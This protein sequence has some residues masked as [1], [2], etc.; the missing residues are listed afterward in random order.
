[1]KNYLAEAMHAIGDIPAG[2]PDE[3]RRYAMQLRSR[4]Y[5]YHHVAQ[6]IHNAIADGGLIDGGL[7]N[8]LK[9]EAQSLTADIDGRLANEVNALADYL[10][11]EA[12]NLAHS[13]EDKKRSLKRLADQLLHRDQQEE[14]QRKQAGRGGGGSW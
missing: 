2:N 12:T 4:A 10:D 3:M 14:A 9:S 11:R 7:A 13:Q 8:R 5:A 6:E 1:M